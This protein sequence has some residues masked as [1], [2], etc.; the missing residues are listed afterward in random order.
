MS[1]NWKTGAGVGNHHGPGFVYVMEDTKHKEVKIGHSRNP[2]SRVKQTKKDRPDT[3]L[4][5]YTKANKMN[6]K[7][8]AAQ[9]AVEKHGMKKVARKATGRYSLPPGVTS[10][11]VNK[12]KRRAVYSQNRTIRNR[13]QQYNKDYLSPRSKANQNTA[14][15]CQEVV[16]AQY[17]TTTMT[18][19]LQHR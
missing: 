9:H 11:D 18:S 12:T 19:Y 2:K 10:K 17:V 8:T 7:K 13:K 1:Y 14:N 5:G 15:Y 3:T 6:R 4:V 16:K